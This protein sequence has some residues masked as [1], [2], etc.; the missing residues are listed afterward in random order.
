MS[1]TTATSTST[2]FEFSY[3]LQLPEASRAFL[4]QCLSVT[5]YDA[6]RPSSSSSPSSAQTL[7]LLDPKDPL[8]FRVSFAPPRPMPLTTVE[9]HVARVRGGGRW[10]FEIQLEAS[11]PDLDG[12]ITLECTIGQTATQAVPIFASGD[13]PEPFRAELSSDTP[14]SFDIRQ[15]SPVLLP[16]AKG[17]G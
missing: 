3:R 9:L 12:V 15:V 8:Q 1:S 5:P 4:E 7:T 11:E 16:L 6:S 14:L 2:P 13:L 17:G 10:R